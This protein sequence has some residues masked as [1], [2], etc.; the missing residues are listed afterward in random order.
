M[1]VTSLISALG[2]RCKQLNASL[3][4]TE[5]QVIKSYTDPFL[6]KKKK[7]IKTNIESQVSLSFFPLLDMAWSF[8]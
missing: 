8:S 2:V 3:L 7:K 4:Y 1:T 6:T 5:F